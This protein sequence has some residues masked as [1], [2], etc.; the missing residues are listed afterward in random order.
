MLV[1]PILGLLSVLQ[2]TTR[3]RLTTSRLCHEATWT[4]VRPY[5][6]TLWRP[7]KCLQSQL[8][9]A[10]ATTS[11]S[12]FALASRPETSTGAAAPGY[13]LVAGCLEQ[14]ALG[15]SAVPLPPER[16]STLALTTMVAGSSPRT[17]RCPCYSD[18]A[19]AG[20]LDGAA[21]QSHERA[22]CGNSTSNSLQD[23]RASAL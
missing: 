16:G 17:T 15:A 2:E 18:V 6:D 22:R 19:Y 3:L 13:E 5:S 9:G 11:S 21:R 4:P 10:K 14:L 20:H 8:L 12:I 1:S 7:P 23:V